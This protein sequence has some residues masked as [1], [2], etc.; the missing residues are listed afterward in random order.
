L[1]YDVCFRL[2]AISQ[3]THHGMLYVPIG[4]TFGS[5]MFKMDEPRGGSPYGAGTYAGSGSRMP[6]ETELAMAEHQGQLTAKVAK[7]LAAK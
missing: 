6:S 3:L 4:Y 2:T 5:G 1:W 7:L